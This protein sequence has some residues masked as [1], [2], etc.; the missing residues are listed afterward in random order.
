MNRCPVMGGMEGGGNFYEGNKSNLE[1][2]HIFLSN[3]QAEEKNLTA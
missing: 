3:L 2:V 1:T